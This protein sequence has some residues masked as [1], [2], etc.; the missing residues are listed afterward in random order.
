MIIDLQSFKKIYRDNLDINIIGKS[1]DNR[2]IYEVILGKSNSE[3]HVL[4]V[5]NI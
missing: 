2:D 1:L 5:G 3:K 4:M